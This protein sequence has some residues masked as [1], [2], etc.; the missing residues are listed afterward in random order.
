MGLARGIGRRGVLT[1]A[2]AVLAGC[3]SPNATTQAA[4][5]QLGPNQTGYVYVQAPII[6]TVRDL[7]V[8]DVNK[9][10]DLNAIEIYVLMSSP[11]GVVDVAQDMIAFIDKT[12]TYEG[13]KFTMHNVGVV[14]SAACYVFLA[15]RHRL[16]VPRGG[17]LFH[18][19]FMVANGA[20]TSSQ[21]QEESAKVQRTDRS[22]LAML[23]SKTRL[24]E[25]EASS[26]VRRTVVLNAE[27]ARRDGVIDAISDFTLPPGANIGN[28]RT[29]PNGRAP[30]GAERI[31]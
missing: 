24:T 6:S 30:V 2:G 11:G 16:S 9:L 29:V 21:L 28:I 13:V 31:K 8:A 17:F 3:Q 25:D 26:F 1:G 5:F 20:I 12:Q 4:G 19:E 15:A 22:F 23:T 18:E 14:A 27:E 10:R 7:F